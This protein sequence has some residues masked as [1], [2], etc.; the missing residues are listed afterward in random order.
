[1]T[2]KE[3]TKEWI[4]Y[5]GDN[6]KAVQDIKLE[7]GDVVFYCWPN[8]GFWNPMIKEGNGNYY[9]KDIPHKEVKFV[10]LTHKEI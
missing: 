5:D 6:S 10:R 8:A 7:N 3:L 2:R 4:P 9:N 1:M